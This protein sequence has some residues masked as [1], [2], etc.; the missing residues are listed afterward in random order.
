MGLSQDVIARLSGQIWGWS[1]AAPGDDRMR[2]AGLDPT[3]SRMV[4]AARL[5]GEIIGFPRHLSQHVG[6]SVITHGRLDELCPIENAAMEDRTIIEWDKDDID[7][8]GLLKV[9]ILAL[10]MLTAIRNALTLLADHR[11]QKLTLANVPPENVP[12]CNAR[13]MRISS[14]VSKLIL[15]TTPM[16][17]QT[18]EPDRCSF[19]RNIQDGM[20]MKRLPSLPKSS[21]RRSRRRSQ[22]G[23][24]PGSSR[25]MAS[26]WPVAKHGRYS[27]AGR[28]K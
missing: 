8:L 13:R 25:S 4:L 24:P 6:G 3:D 10:G 1:S 22:D 20:I 18:A 15:Q 17:S 23:M 19:R 7:A 11:G 9:D 16:N 2:D 26:L 5:I 12:V 28:R 14:T 21:P 27:S